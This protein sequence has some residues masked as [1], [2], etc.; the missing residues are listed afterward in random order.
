V[1]GR[2]VRGKEGEGARRLKERGA[3]MG[4]LYGGNNSVSGGRWKG[5]RQDGG[6]KG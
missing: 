1:A 5:V 2:T 4:S 3:V 6:S